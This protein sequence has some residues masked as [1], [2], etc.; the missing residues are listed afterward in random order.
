M[1]W[2]MSNPS[3]HLWWSIKKSAEAHMTASKLL[4]G[5][6]LRSSPFATAN[7]R[8]EIHLLDQVEQCLFRKLCH[9]LGKGLRR[10][11]GNTGCARYGKLTA[12]GSSRQK[13]VRSKAREVVYEVRG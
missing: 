8:S 6:A 12:Q 1:L 5:H 3:P 10:G 13:L 11:E 2:H 4:S 7:L 9:S